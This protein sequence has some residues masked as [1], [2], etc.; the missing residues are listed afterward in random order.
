MNSHLPIRIYRRRGS[1]LLTV[2]ILVFMM[3]MLV[4]SIL[5]WSVTERRINMRTVYWIEARNAAEALCEYGASQVVDLYNNYASPPALDPFA[6]TTSSNVP[7]ALPS[8]SFFSGSEINTS[9]LSSSNPNGLELVGGKAVQVPSSGNLFYVDPND[10]TNAND[11]LSRQ[12]V[13]RH[14]IVVMAK[15]TAVPKSGDA[16]VTAYVTETVS[17]RGEPLFA[18][19]I[20]YANNDLELTN[21]GPA[22]DVYGPVHVNGNLFVSCD[23]SLTFHYPV[24]ATGNVYHSNLGTSGN[25]GA[26]NAGSVSFATDTTGTNTAPM[27]AS[28]GTYNGKWC[29]STMGAD[30]GITGLSNLQPLVTNDFSG[31]NNDPIAY[32]KTTWNNNL[33]TGSMGVA[34]YNPAGFTLPVDSSG[35]LPDALSAETGNTDKHVGPTGTLVAGNVS[36]IN[37]PPDQTLSTSDTYY[38]GKYALEQAKFSNQTGLYVLVQI[39]AG[40]GGQPDT[41]TITFYGPPV[42]GNVGTSGYG[43]NGG[44]QLGQISVSSSSATGNEPTGIVSFVPYQAT[45]TGTTSGTGTVTTYGTTKIGT[46]YYY[47]TT[48]KTGAT[49]TNNISRTYNGSSYSDTVTGQSS[50]GGSTGSTTNSASSYSSATA[51]LAA[52]PGGGATNYNMTGTPSTS[53]TSA[54]SV[55]QGLYDQRQQT[56]VDLIQIDMGA[57]RTAL[58][59]VNTGTVTGAIVN[60]N[61]GGNIWG[62]GSAGTGVAAD[63]TSGWNGGIYVDVEAP[64]GNQASVGLANG[65]VASGSSLIP[66]GTSGA[67]KI[68]G[69]N[70]GLTIATNAPMYVEGNFNSDGSITSSS[71]QTPDD[72]NTTGSTSAEV[73]VALVSD[74]ITILSP[75]YFGNTGSN[76][77]S[78]S[79][80][81]FPTGATPGVTTLNKTSA[82]NAYNSFS[83][84]DPSTLNLGGSGPEVAAAFISGIDASTGGNFSGGAHNFPRFLE[85]WGGTVA[86]RGSIVNLFDSKVATGLWNGSTYYSAPTRKWGYDQ[87]FQNGT[88]PP[89]TP[90]VISFRRIY[91][92]DLSSAS[93]TALRIDS[94]KGW[95]SEASH[96]VSV[97]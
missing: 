44:V 70:Q 7:L 5:G 90:H 57:L 56:G 42:P 8:S 67:N 34:P 21:V 63:N 31:A 91:F 33:M 24:S 68:V 10:P 62:A 76:N 13:A 78:F 25:N 32:A 3:C 28:S 41:A 11:P 45:A 81:Y 89:L 64:T 69:P 65:R 52:A 61:N 60:N 93:Y 22:M 82:S 39:A 49:I 86:I 35:D 71:A 50:T 79:N 43:P 77:S 46:K 53:I 30:V 40:T 96:F 38:N 15:A 58:Q 20:F 72:G 1:A 74:A 55:T 83:T 94:T 36:Y 19:A 23:T 59:D 17:V 37:D 80:A 4:A 84:V 95:P 54:G 97:H 27:L 18:N 48:P 47:T 73:P 14:D 51:A 92:N 66:N 9:A 6:G 29:D 87:I 2:I 88:Y 16:P 75:G 26:P 85:N 12:M